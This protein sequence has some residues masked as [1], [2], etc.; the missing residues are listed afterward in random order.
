MSHVIYI[1]HH[2][3]ALF[4]LPRA[5]RPPGLPRPWS[6][7]YIVGEEVAGRTNYPGQTERPTRQTD[8]PTNTHRSRA[9]ALIR[10][11]QYIIPARA[12]S[13]HSPHSTRGLPKKWGNKSV[14][15]PVHV[16][17]VTFKQGYCETPCLHTEKSAPSKK[18][19]I[20]VANWYHWTAVLKQELDTYSLLFQ[21]S[22]HDDQYRQTPNNLP[23]PGSF[24][25]ATPRVNA[26]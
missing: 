14:T 13:L 6:R 8:R 21:Q 1:V 15:L 25:G 17:L 26:P 20:L 2:K 5:G 24:R 23:G 4:I 7:E 11:T 19:F 10:A 22:L 9:R 18:C 16:W 12:R 3:R